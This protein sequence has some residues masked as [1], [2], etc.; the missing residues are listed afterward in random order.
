MENVE[1]SSSRAFGP[2]MLMEGVY[3]RPIQKQEYLLTLV[4]CAEDEA[5]EELHV[6]FYMLIMG[7]GREKAK[8]GKKG[9]DMKLGRWA[10][11]VASFGS[12]ISCSRRAAPSR[13]DRILIP[14]WNAFKLPR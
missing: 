2:H 8:K 14:P 13:N 10:F 9:K 12:T 6:V 11:I 4:E 1:I 3:S 7:R 5:G